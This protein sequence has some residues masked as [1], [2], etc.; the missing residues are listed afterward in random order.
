M[1]I[2]CSRRDF[3]TLAAA[4][5]AAVGASSAGAT[6]GMGNG[7]ESLDTLARRR[8]LRFGSA[9]SYWQLSDPRYCALM[10]E[11][12][13]ILVTENELKWPQVE[14][15]PGTFTFQ[16]GDALA[17][18][19]ADNH[20]LLRGH[21][22]LW[23]KSRYLPDW[24]RS[25]PLG[26]HP[27]AALEQL[28]RDH[29]T[30]EI[31][32]YPQ[33]VSWDVVNEAIG[34]QTGELRQTLFTRH[35]GPEAI[36]LC[37]RAARAAAPHAQLVYNDYMSWESGSATHRAGVL[38]LLEGLRKR[39]VPVDALG[40]QSHIGSNGQTRSPPEEAAWR[41][42]LDEVTGMGYGLLITEFDVNDGGLP[43]DPARRDRM[44]ADYARRYLDITLSYRQ[45]DY[46]LTW[47]LVD[48]DSWLQRLPPRADGT[49]RRPL[50]FDSD[51][52]PTALYFAMADAF[53]AAPVR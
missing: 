10:R 2:R 34:T 49:P 5:A 30:R 15:R 44:I 43:T 14:P 40:L 53:R 28:L 35:L 50:P 1:R 38:R 46:V 7:P 51:Y 17:R 11:Q 39:N 36:D 48:K 16:R 27:R 47:G 45:L 8:G 22:L 6:A 52:R 33:V 4:A 25:D 32:H 31:A 12:C 29:I 24:V 41:R 18:F 26:A 20:L 13:G 37:Y 9:M 19:A 23:Q 21:N 42:F 3:I